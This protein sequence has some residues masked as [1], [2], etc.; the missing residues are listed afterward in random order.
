VN[1]LNVVVPNVAPG[2]SLPLQIAVGGTT[3]SAGITMAV[4][5]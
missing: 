5:Q 4:S 2:N 3:T 1:Q